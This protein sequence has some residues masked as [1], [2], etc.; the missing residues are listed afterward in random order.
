M[1]NLIFSAFV[2][3][4][5]GMVLKKVSGHNIYYKGFLVNKDKRELTQIEYAAFIL[6]HIFFWPLSFWAPV[7]RAFM[8]INKETGDEYPM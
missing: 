5:L 6:V 2:G 1:I 7:K 8:L 4:G 3:F